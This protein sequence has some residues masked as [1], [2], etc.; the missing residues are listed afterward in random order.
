LVAAGMIFIPP[1]LNPDSN[2]ERSIAVLPFINE[3]P[4]DSNKYFINGIMEELLNNLQAIGDFRVLSRTS[5]EKFKG[6][7]KPTIPEIAK[8]L[9]V[10]YIVEGSGQKYGTM[11]RFRV[12]L[13]KAKGK[14]DHLWGKPFEIDL[15][16][17]SDLFELQSKIAKAI[18]SELNAVITPDENLIIGKV[19]TYDMAAYNLYLKAEEYSRDYS[20][21]YILSDYQ[22][23]VNLY[24]AAIE[25]DPSFAKAFVGLA[26]IYSTRY[27]YEKFFTN[28]FLD[29]CLYFT[30][31]A[32]GMDD[33]LADAYYVKAWYYA[34]IADSKEAL[35]NLD[36]TLSLNPNHASAYMRKGYIL[37]WVI[38]DYKTGILNYQKALNLISGKERPALIRSL[39]RA[40]LDAGFVEKARK[41]YEDAYDLDNSDL[42]YLS[43]LIWLEFSN[44]NFIEAVNLARKAAAIDSTFSTDLFI[45]SLVPGNEQEALS[46]AEKLVK[47]GNKQGATLLYQAHRIGYAYYKSGLPEDAD[48]Y[49][50][51]QVKFGEDGIKLKRLLT[52]RRAF[53]Y[54]LAATYAFIGQKEKA[55][56]LLEE[57]VKL[58]FYQLWWL[59]LIKNDP[60]FES[61]RNEERFQNLIRQMQIKH[62][63]EHERVRKWLEENNML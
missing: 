32:L 1:L 43:S 10:N 29:S 24:N 16:Q 33:R 56:Q 59:T 27:Y 35:D 55:Y 34:M 2:L 4:V 57:F 13:I 40:Y 63:A 14:E 45:Y 42:N 46:Y 28:N 8:E 58:K 5:T 25:S 37:T 47:T 62:D 51:L 41:L 31:K 23:S 18:A 60:L 6:P 38:F 49:F 26:W 53:H 44:G 20:R 54:D 22:T 48:Y 36:K 52:Q 30:D 11:L 39:A 7:E 17:T 3:S 21:N 50:N 19:P 61:I 9:G 15:K 12:Q